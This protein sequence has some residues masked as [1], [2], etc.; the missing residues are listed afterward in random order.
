M[1]PI[2]MPNHEGMAMSD[3]D[4][5]SPKHHTP[6]PPAGAKLGDQNTDKRAALKDQKF[7]NQRSRIDT[8]QRSNARQNVPKPKGNKK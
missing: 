7:M 4:A 8:V 1:C 3:D 2:W 5:K 6:P